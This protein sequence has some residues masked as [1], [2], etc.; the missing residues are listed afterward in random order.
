[1]KPQKGT[2][3][4]EQP[5]REEQIISLLKAGCRGE[6]NRSVPEAQDLDSNVLQGRAMFGG[7]DVSDANSLRQRQEEKRKAQGRRG[8][9]EAGQRR[10]EGSRNKN[11]WSGASLQGNSDEE[12]SAKMYPA[13][14]WRHA[15]GHNENPRAIGLKNFSGLC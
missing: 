3:D 13:C 14:L 15:P 10:A 9:P 5:R 8:G 11:V 12:Q 7:M 1:V 4:E 2:T 6:D